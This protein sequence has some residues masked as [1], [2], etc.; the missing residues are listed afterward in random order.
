[1]NKILL[2][3][4]SVLL[5]ATA[6]SC[7]DFLDKE[8]DTSMAEEQV[9]S[10]KENTRGFLANIYTNLP[11]GFSGYTNG[12]FLGASRDCM[13][14]NALSFWSV[15]Y[16]HGILT[17]SYSA[18]NHPLL[19][20]WTTDVYGIRKANQ[21]MKNARE[22][23]IGNA[24]RSGDDNRL[25][26][27]YMAEAKLLR[28][29]F[30]FDIISWFGDAPIIAEDEDG[31]PIV[32]DLSNAGAMNM[33]RTDAADALKWVADQCDLVKDILPFRYDNETENWGRMNGAAA[34]ALKAR[35]LLYRAS[36]L[37]NP[38]NVS[39]Y[40]TQAAK[41][42]RDFISVNNTQSNPYKLYNT[43]DVNKT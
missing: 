33:A 14:D 11:D 31:I 6:Y 23:V 42:A 13:T 15:H 27:R 41:A 2:Y 19:G 26:D 40:W 30:H 21:F 9:F 1:M 38:G 12:Q 36:K 18:T 24:E 3:I 43:G 32:F 22:S 25:Y 37:N 29:I 20:F 17:D 16:Y 4:T 34:Y 10:N 8:Y 39:E 28:A 7:S 5:V 35:A